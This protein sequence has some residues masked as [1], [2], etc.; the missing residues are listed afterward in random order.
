MDG[1][2]VAKYRISEK[3][4]AQTLAARRG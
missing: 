2:K 4:L 1:K 3:E